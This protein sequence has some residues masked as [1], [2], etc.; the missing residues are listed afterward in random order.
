MLLSFMSREEA[1]AKQSKHAVYLVFS[2]P[3]IKAI[4][5]ALRVK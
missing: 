5:I 4:P 2:P 1:K 3:M